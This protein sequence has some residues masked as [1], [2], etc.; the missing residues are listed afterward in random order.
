[1]AGLSKVRSKVT[2]MALDWHL[3]RFPVGLASSTCP[4]LGHSGHVAE[5]SYLAFGGN[6]AR[7][8]ALC[9]FRSYTLCCKVSHRGPFAK[10]KH[11]CRLYLDA[12]FFQSLFKI[13]VTT[14]DDRNK[15]HCKQWQICVVL[16]RKPL[17]IFHFKTCVYMQVFS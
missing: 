6:A 10:K 16:K 14:C 9:E 13:C 1:M 3:G 7:H 5:F 11:L 17:F 2:H 15:D 4:F 8:S 12:V